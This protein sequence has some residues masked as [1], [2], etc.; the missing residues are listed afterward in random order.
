MIQFVIWCIGGIDFS[1]GVGVICDVFI[2][3]DL[4]L[5]VCVIIM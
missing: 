1:G 4:Y 2:L 3:V 5:Y